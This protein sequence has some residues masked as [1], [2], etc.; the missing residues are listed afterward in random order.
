LA[1][2]HQLVDLGSLTDGDEHLGGTAR[3]PVVRMGKGSA[4]A[5]G[6]ADGDPVTVGTDRGALT[7]PA[8]ITEM[9]DG[10]VW[11]PTNSPGAT[12]RR[13]LGATSGAV[14]RISAP[15]TTE[16]VA[17]DAAGRPGPLLN[18]SGGNQ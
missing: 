16:P 5:L 7:L 6:I 11:L 17:A 13:S 1:T 4:E 12:V 18:S 2:W 8:A 14:V 3:P 10:V 9:P 15:G